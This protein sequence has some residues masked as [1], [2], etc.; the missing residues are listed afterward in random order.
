MSADDR[1]IHD[2]LDDRLTRACAADGHPPADPDDPAER[3]PCGEM[4]STPTVGPSSR[5]GRAHLHL[6]TQL[7]F[8]VSTGPAS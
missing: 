7:A 4:R 8:E 1:S 6:T 5:R 3:C 2:E